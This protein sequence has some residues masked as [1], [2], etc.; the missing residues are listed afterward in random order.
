[1]S[2]IVRN[3]YLF[4]VLIFFVSLSLPAQE[5]AS[6]W[7]FGENAG[8]DFNSGSP[9]ADTNGAL[10]TIE[11]CATISDKRGN[12]L[13]YTDGVTVW[14]RNHQIMPTGN[15]LLG[16]SSSTQSGIIVPKPADE[17]T[18]Y[19][20]TVD[21]SNG[22][23]GLNYYTVDMTLNGG[24]GDVV[25]ANNLPTATNLLLAP[26]SEKITAVKVDNEDAFWVISL[27]QDKFHVFKID[28]TGVA[29][30]SVNGNDGFSGAADA[31]GYL[32]VAPDGTKLVSANMSSGL[33]L[34]DFDSQTGAISNERL[35][36]VLGN[37]AYGVEFSPQSKKLY[38]STGEFEDA[39]EGL[40]QF[41]L[42]VA[43]PSRENINATRVEL[44]TYFNSR[45]ALQIG[46]DG[47]I[48]RNIDGTSFLGVITNP[49]GDGLAANYVHEAVNLGGRISRQGLPPFIQSFFVATVD[50]EN[51]CFGD[52][53]TFSLT[54][55]DEVVSILWDFGEGAATSTELNPTHV[56]SAPGDYTITV[57]ITTAEETR[58][59]TQ[60]LTIFALPEINQNVILKQCDDDNDGISTFNLLEAEG[61]ITSDS[62]RLTLSYHLSNSDAL[63]A[64]NPITTLTSFSNTTASQ[65]FVRVENRLG[66]FDIAELE[67]QVVTTAIPA[68]FNIDILECD[69]SAIDNDANNG[70]TT[71]NLREATN[72][73]LGLFPANQNLVVSYYE[74]TDDALIEQ[75]AIDPDNYRN[76][77][78]PFFQEIIV[79]V[80]SEN[81]NSCVGLGSHITLS[82]G[83][84]PEFEVVE[85][86]FI[87]TNQLP[88]PVTTLSVLNASDDY[89]YEWRD[90]NSALLN[91]NGS[92]DSIEVTEPGTYSVTAISSDD[93]STI[94]TISVVASN[95]ATIDDIIVNDDSAN[96]S[97]TVLVSGPG[98]YE[99]ALN[100]PDGVYRDQ[101]VF[102]NL[103]AGVY[104]V[105]VRDKNGCGTVSQEVAVIGYP[106]FFTPNGD[107]FNDTWQVSGIEL[108]PGSEVF[109]FDRFGKVLVKLDPTGDGW[110][111][112][113]KGKLMPQSDYWFLA[114]LEDGRVRRGHFSLIRR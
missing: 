114:K 87:C 95:A 10:N 17:N 94:K 81:D 110:D 111:G 49:E 73:I 44:H 61:S 55:N 106:R 102:N 31:R 9:L 30:Q 99:Y 15:G 5:E 72:T 22:L 65:L 29:S 58:I 79:R 57:E 89:T 92:V 21:W 100:D 19:I 33:F 4:W 113:Y 1:M 101:N 77:N 45:A 50:V 18:Y 63:D 14:N 86:A 54:T 91:L 78:S 2:K 68:D 11:G 70:I 59:I 85:T 37:S 24:L 62:S 51:V 108:Q 35:L 43:N 90:Q 36:D 67:L 23:N 64:N 109:I 105:Y 28:A 8:L 104:T 80:D 38:V 74:N 39:T 20:F 7:F 56:Y 69:T 84:L 3:N 96:N 88:E 52:T 53:T 47:R 26:T 71:F 83:A 46:I 25:G 13:F 16:N 27:K 107:T 76:E 42:D 75:N 41:T 93:C 112:K 34:Y 98:D 32:K 82:V 12:L 66:C 48:Y 103:L 6:R 40:Y 60:Q 97:I